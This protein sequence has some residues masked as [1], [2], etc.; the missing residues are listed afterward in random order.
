MFD[1]PVNFVRTYSFFEPDFTYNVLVNDPMLGAVSVGAV[2]RNRDDRRKWY[3]SNKTWTGG[4]DLPGTFP[5]R[6]DAA[7]A[8]VAEAREQQQKESA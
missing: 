2:A 6:R 7:A 3:A 1:R 8:L 5:T 4:D